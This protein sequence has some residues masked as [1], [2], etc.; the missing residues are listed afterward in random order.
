MDDR[1]LTE[2][3]RSL[4]DVCDGRGLTLAVAESCTGGALAAAITDLPGVSSF[5]LG[6]IVSYANEVKRELL[7]VPADVL[8]KQGAVSEETARAMAE[9]VRARIG[10][11]VGLS[12][13]GI[14]GPGG[15]TPTKPVGLVYIA[16]STPERTLVR[17][18]VWPGDR[19][20][21]RTASVRAALE[22]AMQAL[23]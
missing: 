6:G 19:A 17:R 15:E 21:V 9:G 2:L 20:A 16:A 4:A 12:T 11:D 14:A 22:L 18:D 13:T 8:A 10:A 3:V 1:D 5:F 23:E 7:A